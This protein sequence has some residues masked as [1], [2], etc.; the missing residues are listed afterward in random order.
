M[1]PRRSSGD[2]ASDQA[3]YDE[4]IQ[5]QQ[6]VNHAARAVVEIYRLTGRSREMRS[7]AGDDILV[8]Q[9]TS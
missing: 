5:S 7:A 9:S 2:V 1:K 6:R 8:F 3:G 4:P